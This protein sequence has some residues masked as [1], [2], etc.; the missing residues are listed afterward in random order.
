MSAIVA[1]H[2]SQVAIKLDQRLLQK[3]KP[4]KVAIVAV[5]RKLLVISFGILK[6]QA[7][8]DPNYKTK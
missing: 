1:S 2:H 7:R 8:F 5:T 4:K 6:S 3:G